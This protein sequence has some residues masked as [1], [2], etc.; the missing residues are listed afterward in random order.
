MG[1]GNA[2]LSDV[3]DF[4]PGLRRTQRAARLQRKAGPTRSIAND[5]PA[6]CY[7]GRLGV[8][9]LTKRS[10][11]PRAGKSGGRD[12]PARSRKYA[13]Q[14]G[15]PGWRGDQSGRR[16]GKRA[17]PASGP[18]HR[19]CLPA[20]PT[21]SSLGA[22]TSYTPTERQRKDKSSASPPTF[23][24]PSRQDDQVH[25]GNGG[26]APVH[27]HQDRSSLCRAPG[28]APCRLSRYARRRFGAAPCR[29]RRSIRRCAKRGG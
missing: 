29:L 17:S 5:M 25:Q 28:R 11:R 18:Q 19:I 9:G 23:L 14:P 15:M 6:F 24:L 20:E 10:P 4:E 7:I 1:R 8:H 12:G 13:P 21:G 27:V 2:F 22:S 16:R 26:R 3:I